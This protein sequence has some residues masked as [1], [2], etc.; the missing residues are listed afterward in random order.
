MSELM[1]MQQQVRLLVVDDIPIIA[2]GLSEL[3]REEPPRP[4]EVYKA[5]SA[6]E[7]FERMERTP[8]D[9][10]VTDIKMPEITG[11][12]MLREINRRWPR[13]K[14]IF[15]TSYHDFEYAREAV[16]L[17]GFDFILKTEGD[18]RILQAV[19]GA[20]EALLAERESSELLAQAQEQY[21]L[22]LPSLRKVFLRELL[23]GLHADDQARRSEA[24]ATLGVPLLAQRP[25]YLA[26]ARLDGWKQTMTW[27]DQAMLHYSVANILEE[28][29]S[30]HV[31]LMTLSLE[32]SHLVC[33]WQAEAGAE[34]G[35]EQDEEEEEEE[36][37]R[38]AY[39]TFERVQN[40][41]LDLLKLQVS[42]I[43]NAEPAPWPR[44]GERLHRLELLLQ[45]GLGLNRELLTTDAELEQSGR[46][47][48]ASAVSGVGSRAGAGAMPGAGAWAGS[49]TGAG[50]EAMPGAGAGAG[51][52]AEA[53]TGAEAWTGAGAVA[54]AGAESEAEAGAGQPQVDG[55]LYLH[56][57]RFSTL[58]TLLAGGKQEDFFL[59]LGEL[60]VTVRAASWGVRLE[61]VH[62][63]SHLFISYL[64]R[65][66]SLP[67]AAER[68]GLEP[69][70]R[71]ETN[72][73]WDAFIAYCRRLAEFLFEY[74]VLDQETRSNR[75]ITDLQSYIRDH[76]N[77][78]LSLTSLGERV[79]L[80]PTYLSRLYKQ[81]TGEGISEYI[82]EIRLE[83]AKHLLE[84]SDRLIQDIAEDIGYQSGIAF[85]RF[86]KKMMNITPQDYRELKQ[87]QY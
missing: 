32:S 14:V 39:D 47:T 52:G 73:D 83:Q 46:S 11:L 80:H 18:D 31:R 34:A 2:D 68:L 81:V 69:L 85:T 21:R 3:F 55:E 53:R 16:K 26:L 29:L 30:P 78:D 76:I 36:T 40:I 45:R 12:E 57:S 87:Q 86:F 38:F 42:F 62:F 50:A 74:T 65:R 35:G 8:I 15:L 49:R 23:Q 24:F 71:T 13:C 4:M 41:C 25:V 67:L 58:Q 59:L 72:P 5:Y 10:V 70:A 63:L 19:A 27:S 61:A 44:A 6:P 77:R 22:A 48:P 37:F 64:N 60:D 82:M 17:G 1:G 84:S 79:H 56:P 9:I 33:L 75:L 43:L 7:A 28:C 54:G 20:A 66:Q 51:S